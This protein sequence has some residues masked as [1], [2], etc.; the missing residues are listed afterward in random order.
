M[1]RQ[2][3]SQKLIEKI[4]RL[5]RRIEERFPGSGLSRVCGEVHEAAGETRQ[6][7]DRIGRPIVWLR[8]LVAVTILIVVAG[9]AETL[10]SVRIADTRFS[11][12]DLIQ[13]LEAAL[14]AVVMIGAAVVFLVTVELRFK[15]ARALKAINELRALA[16]VIDM[17][18]LTKDPA[19]ILAAGRET[20]SSPRETM[21]S[22]DLQRYLDYC[23]ET[24]S[25]VGKMAALYGQYLGDAVV[26]A[27]VN[28]LEG[29]TTGLS[30]K[31][32]QKIMVLH[33]YEQ[34]ASKR[35]AV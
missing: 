33:L 31:I 15:R 25:L 24:L 14:S 34:D 5:H 7:C 18:Q 21:D 8:G 32:W 28:D 20:A 29:L 13:A 22:F 1:F 17:H 23:S 27:A 10:V 2:L 30:R 3:D 4:D 35:P 19:R 11:L 6:A 16:H 12:T 9:L 26:V